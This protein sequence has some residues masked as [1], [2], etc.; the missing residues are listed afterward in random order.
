MVCINATQACVAAL[1]DH[2]ANA[3]WLQK[4]IVGL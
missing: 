1:S 3:F 2:F 4:R